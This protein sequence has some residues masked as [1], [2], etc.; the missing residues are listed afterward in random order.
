MTD[1]VLRRSK[2]KDGK[3]LPGL[4]ESDVVRMERVEGGWQFQV[5][6]REIGKTGYYEFRPLNME[7]KWRDAGCRRTRRGCC[8]SAE[9]LRSGEYVFKPAY[10]IDRD[11]IPAQV[12]P[13]SE[14]TQEIAEHPS[15]KGDAA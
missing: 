6:S 14:V 8:L 13:W 5:P 7:G 11:P 4:W 1:I 9:K 15:V 12:I 2:G 10:S 3:A